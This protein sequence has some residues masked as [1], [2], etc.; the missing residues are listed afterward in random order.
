MLSSSKLLFF[1]IHFFPSFHIIILLN[2]QFS[3]SILILFKLN[4]QLLHSII[5]ECLVLVSDFVLL[6]NSTHRYNHDII[7][8]NILI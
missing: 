7:I 1:I 4:S 5:Q 8:F 2:L 3:F 6:L